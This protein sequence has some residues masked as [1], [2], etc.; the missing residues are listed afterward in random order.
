MQNTPEKE[1][2]DKS[3]FETVKFEV[4]S[5]W[6]VLGQLQ[7][8]MQNDLERNVRKRLATQTILDMVNQTRAYLDKIEELCNEA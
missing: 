2:L 3:T 7:L 6:R 5:G 8:R 1:Y 4:R